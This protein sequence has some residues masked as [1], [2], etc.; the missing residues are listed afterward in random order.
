[1]PAKSVPDRPRGFLIPI[2]GAEDKMADRR[3]LKRFIGLCGGRDAPVVVVPTASALAIP[4][5]LMLATV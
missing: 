1:M 5:V 3:I 2:G 4:V